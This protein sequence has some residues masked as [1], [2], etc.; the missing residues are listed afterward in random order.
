MIHVPTIKL[1]VVRALPFVLASFLHTSS[2]YA[3][4]SKLHHIKVDIFYQV[5][6]PQYVYTL[7]TKCVLTFGKHPL[8]IV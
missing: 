7:S 2:F 6:G 8:Q 1:L 3:M 5:H 4:T